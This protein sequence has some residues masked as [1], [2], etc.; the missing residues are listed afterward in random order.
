MHLNRMTTKTST[1]R[2]AILLT[3]GL[4]SAPTLANEPSEGTQPSKDAQQPGT[5]LAPY[6]V[7]YTAAMDKGITL[8]GT[9]KRT[10]TKKDGNVWLYRTNVDSFIAN[11]DESL[12]LK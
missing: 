6:E 5:E 12:I 7:T 9:A 3:L 1:R 10:L 4:L 2:A 11:I 8:N